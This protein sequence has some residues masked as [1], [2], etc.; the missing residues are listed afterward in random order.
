[1]R[2]S[3][4][5]RWGGLGHSGDNTLAT[6]SS[7]F[8]IS[9]RLD[10]GFLESICVASQL[11]TSLNLFENLNTFGAEVSLSARIHDLSTNS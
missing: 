10:L 4:R 7:L 6:C 3:E 8:N 2:V 11:A 9:S 5:K 1:M